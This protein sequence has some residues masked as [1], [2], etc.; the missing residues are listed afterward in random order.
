MTASFTERLADAVSAGRPPACVGLDPRIDALP[1]KLAPDAAP[2][3]RIA[4]F[5]REVLPR[6]T[7][8]VPV[9]KPNIAF[10]EC[11]GA[12]GFGAYEEVCRQARAAGLLVVGDVK[13]GDIGSTAAAYARIHLDLADAVTLHPYLGADAVEPFLMRCRRDGRGV[14]VL[15]RTSNPGASDFQDLEL[16]GAPGTTVATSVAAA[17]ARWGAE[18]VDRTGYSAVGA[19]V[20][21]TWPA[22]VARL[23]SLMPHAW[24]LLPGVGAQGGKLSDLAPAFDARGM[25]GLVSQSRGVL[26]CFE[27]G[28]PDW[29][30]RIEAALVAFAAAFDGVLPRARR[31]S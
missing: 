17:V 3:V 5:A 24:F 11:H 10:F 8:H 23:R 30:D 27:P 25:G 14:F 29:L 12:A 20:G 22:E 19:V 1:S 9:L 4:A 18:L 6:I 2:A 16:A 31:P 26:Q 28:D 13:R 15:V 21:A 7:R